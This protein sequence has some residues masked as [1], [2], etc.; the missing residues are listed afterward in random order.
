MPTDLISRTSF[1]AGG[2]HVEVTPG[3]G[4]LAVINPAT[5]QH[6]GT[7]PDC[8]P[9][10]INAAVDS[11]QGALLG[12]WG[13]TSG[14]ERASA[15]QRFAEALL[16]RS[17]E[18]AMLV[19]Q[20][21]GMPIGLSTAANA[22]PAAASLSYYAGLAR[23]ASPDEVRPALSFAGHTVVRREPVGV[24][25]TIVPWNYP[26]GLAF[27]KIA[28]ALAAGCSIVL[29]PSPETSLD[30]RLIADAAD[31]AGLPPG[32]L[33]IVTGAREAGGYLVTHPDVDKVAFTGSTAA[34]RIIAAQC[35]QALKPVTL[36]LGGKSAALVLDDAD[37]AETLGGLAF[38]CFANAGQSCFLNSRVIVARSRYDEVVDGL[39]SLARSFVLGDPMDEATTMGPLITAAQRERVA[40]YVQGAVNDGARLATGGRRPPQ[41]ERGWFYEPTIAVDVDNRST[42]AQEEVFGPV[43]AVIAADDDDDA[44]AKGNDSEFGLGGSVWSADPARAESV[45]RRVQTGTIGVNMWTLDPAAPFGGHKASGLGKEFGPEGLDEY[46]KL[47]SLFVPSR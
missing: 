36:E 5:E 23:A 42:L 32:V 46:V 17:D 22:L 21:N 26:L 30:T 45:A 1:Y 6:L 14:E 38:L 4:S 20:Q 12:E 11:A 37:L 13:R 44:I 16:E 7:I 8:G 35:G 40:A 2:K 33:N 41:L 19:T 34:G 24:V 18:I 39:V 31:E 9:A 27:M 47:S 10:E 43:I 29:K 3:T 25:A 15:M 28:P